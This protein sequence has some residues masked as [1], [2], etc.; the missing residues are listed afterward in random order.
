MLRLNIGANQ[1]IGQPN[2]GS[3]GASVQFEVELESSLVGDPE[4]LQ[5][6]VR[7]LLWCNYSHLIGDTHKLSGDSCCPRQGLIGRQAGPY[8]MIQLL[9]N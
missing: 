9:V 3:R 5:E 8:K 4:H 1:K 2:Y 7:S 6:K